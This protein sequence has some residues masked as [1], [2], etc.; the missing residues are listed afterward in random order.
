MKDISPIVLMAYRDS[1]LVEER[2]GQLSPMIFFAYNRMDTTQK[3]EKAANLEHLAVSLHEAGDQIGK[4]R[5]SVDVRSRNLFHDF[6]FDPK[7]PTNNDVRFF[8]KNLENY[9][10]PKDV[11]DPF[12]DDSAVGNKL[13]DVYKSSQVIRATGYDLIASDGQLDDVKM[14]LT[15]AVIALDSNGQITKKS[16]NF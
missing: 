4:T 5:D 15:E 16:K 6:Y 3:Q 2:G 10:P 13:K 12:Y 14:R 11:P 9:R 1:N 8:G 7:D